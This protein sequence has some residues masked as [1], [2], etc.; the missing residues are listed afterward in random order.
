MIH[1]RKPC[2]SHK[3]SIANGQTLNSVMITIRVINVITLSAEYKWLDSMFKLQSTTKSKIINV[4]ADDKN[5]SYQIFSYFETKIYR[6]LLIKRYLFRDGIG[7]NICLDSRTVYLKI[8][9]N[10]NTTRRCR[11]KKCIAQSW[12]NLVNEPEG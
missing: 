7:V 3:L 9:Y 2:T 8:Q 1:C 4:S 12:S 11:T 5:L 10:R 6:L